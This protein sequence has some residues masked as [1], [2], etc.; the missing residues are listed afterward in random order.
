MSECKK[1][2]G[3]GEV[4]V[5]ES[6]G[7][8]EHWVTCSCQ[9]TPP[10]MD[11]KICPRCGAKKHMLYLLNSNWI[12]WDCRHELEAKPAPP[13]GTEQGRPLTEGEKQAMRHGM[14]CPATTPGNDDDCT[15]GL[16][17]MDQI[18][19]LETLLAAWQKRAAEA[20]KELYSIAA[21]IA[22][23]APKEPSY[24][25][26]L[27]THPIMKLASDGLMRCTTCGSA[28]RDER[29]GVDSDTRIPA[30][31]EPGAVRRETESEVS[32][33]VQF[34]PTLMTLQQL[35]ERS[36]P[37]DLRKLGWSVAVHNDYRR[38]GKTFT[39]WLMVKGTQC[40]AGDGETDAE[41][42]NWIRLNICSACG[43]YFQG[44]H[45]C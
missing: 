18:G 31:S 39:F 15:C 44:V 29:C 7:G 37:D 33:R 9:T 6:G 8:R 34:Q 13:C 22:K 25:A 40:V 26:S 1:C 27:M 4:N 42:L 16:K 19:T 10:R 11:D 12:C 30:P 38:N 3:R 43:I 32:Q 5:L 35:R 20:E 17:W 41:A 28:N 21:I 24:G 2:N 14:N 23:H 45:E 36:S